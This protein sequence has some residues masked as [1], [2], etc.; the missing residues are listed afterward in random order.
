MNTKVLCIKYIF[1]LDHD[2]EP[3]CAIDCAHDLGVLSADFCKLIHTDRKIK[4]FQ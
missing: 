1:I 4:L 2:S 3:D